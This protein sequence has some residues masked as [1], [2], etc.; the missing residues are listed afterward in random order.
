MSKCDI[1]A[2]S[3]KQIQTKV[4]QTL[5]GFRARKESVSTLKQ[6]MVTLL[7]EIAEN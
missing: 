2:Q 5:M 4:A 1:N 7:N 3:L 6:N